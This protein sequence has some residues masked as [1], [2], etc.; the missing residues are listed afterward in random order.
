MLM[1]NFYRLSPARDHRASIGRRGKMHAPTAFLLALCTLTTPCAFFTC[2]TYDACTLFTG[3]VCYIVFCWCLLPDK[4][5][6][7]ADCFF[8]VCR[9]FFSP[10]RLQKQL[11]KQN[12]VLY[13]VKKILNTNTGTHLKIFFNDNLTMLY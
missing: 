2:V 3:G 12:N 9:Y 1:M 8:G 5:L 4:I 11:K 6:Q 13:F 10:E 7:F